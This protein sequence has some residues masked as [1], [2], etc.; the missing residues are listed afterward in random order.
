[1]QL[2][3]KIVTGTAFALALVLSAVIAGG[4]ATLIEQASRKAVRIGLEAAG[5]SWVTVD[6]DGVQVILSG[7]APTEARRFRALTV[8]GT[9]VEASRIVDMTE[10]KTAE[11]LA[12]PEFS[13]EILRNDD[14][15]SLIGLVPKETDRDALLG[16]LKRLARDAAVTDMLESADYP[17]PE[18][19]DSALTFG[20]AVLKSL[21]RSKISISATRVAVTAI[22]D[23]AAEKARIEADLKRRKPARLDLALDISAPRPVITP[24]T[25]RFLI[26]ARGARFDACSADTNRARTRILAAARVAGI[27]GT[28]NCTVG[29]GV[30]SPAWADAVVMG[31]DAMKQLGAGSI[32][33]SDAD[34][35][36]IAAETVPQDVYDRVVGELESNLPEVFSLKAVLTPKPVSAASGPPEFSATLT[37]HGQIQLRGR[38][39]DDRQ[40]EAVESF[41][42][43]RFGDKSVYGATRLDPGLPA[44]WPVRVLAALEALDQMAQG[45]VVVQPD[46]VRLEGVSGDPQGSDTVAR[47]LT[48]R[49]G[50]GARL[51]LSV[52]YDRR[53]DPVLGLPTG[54]ECVAD[55]NAALAVAKIT[56]E[57]GSAV[58]TAEA[59]GALDGLADIMKKCTDYPM[60]VGGHT[61]SQGR[62][63]M[64]L[65]LSQ[66]RAQAVIAAL[67]ARRVLTG[68][69]T[70]QGFGET[71][72]IDDNGTEAGR[73]ANRRIEFALLGEP[74][75]PVTPP[76]AGPDTPNSTEPV[77][78]AQAEESVVAPEQPAPP[79]LLRP[80]AR[81]ATTPETPATAG[82]SAE[83]PRPEAAPPP[84]AP[85]TGPVDATQDAPAA[86]ETAPAEALPAR[87]PA[88][89]APAPELAA[90]PP[91]LVPARTVEVAKPGPD[92][93][94]PTPRPTP[95]N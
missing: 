32:T 20:T 36:L 77:P 93:P 80:P 56:F 40:R 43:A 37:P 71:T 70:A 83:T 6:A 50:E 21:P 44:G 78:P 91:V 22:T 67:E 88:N 81:P 90:P 34:I 60:Q 85:T 73:E 64:N 4:A 89:P 62:E 55:L 26:D 82:P 5:Q 84:E 17:V 69:L 8:A 16:D 12:P 13:L 39:S 65:V 75:A 45:R 28:P 31:L 42:R 72:P 46:L 18:G 61:D 53:L 79:D 14:G 59:A 23:S 94:R 68:N 29:M 1:M 76:S 52:R 57:P 11:A 7:E 3:P 51:D 48:A 2:G 10:V 49:L 35:S 47:I 92:T 19:W 86:T 74:E 38:L 66:D 95:Q 30:P 24:F 33:F 15:I 58:I 9:L 27:T 54:P 63:E 25:L 41:A 87:D